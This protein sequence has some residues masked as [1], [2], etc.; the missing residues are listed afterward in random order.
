MSETLEFCCCQIKIGLVI[1]YN[2]LLLVMVLNLSIGFHHWRDWIVNG[3][4]FVY[5]ILGLIITWKS[6]RANLIFIIILTPLIMAASITS[7]IMQLLNLSEMLQPWYDSPIQNE[8]GMELAFTII[9]A[10]SG[11]LTLILG[12]LIFVNNLRLLRKADE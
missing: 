4:I 6:R 5:M 8:D 11:I 1:C 3:A 12:T 7:N 10:S 2:S 9:I